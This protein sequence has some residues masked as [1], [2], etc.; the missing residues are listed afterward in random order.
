VKVKYSDFTQATRSRTYA[1][2][3]ANGNDILEATSALLATVYPFKRSPRQLGVTLS[4][5]TNGQGDSSG[6]EQ[7]QF[8]F[9]L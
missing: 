6:Q 2:P 5:L 8:D 4:S 7:P 9:K 3:F 1:L